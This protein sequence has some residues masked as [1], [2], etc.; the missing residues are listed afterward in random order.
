MTMNQ[1]D[2]IIIG[3]GHEKWTTNHERQLVVCC[4]WS[5]VPRS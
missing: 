2:A 4:P 1:Y 3:G 5:V